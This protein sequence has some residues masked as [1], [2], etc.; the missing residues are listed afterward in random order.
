MH[1]CVAVTSVWPCALQ[2]VYLQA[3]VRSSSV[4]ARSR[5]DANLV[6]PGV[7]MCVCVCTRT[8]DSAQTRGS[9]SIPAKCSHLQTL[10]LHL[11]PDRMLRPQEVTRARVSGV[12]AKPKETRPSDWNTYS[13]GQEISLLLVNP[14]VHCR[15]HKTESLQ[16][17]GP[18]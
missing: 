14:K 15:V 11:L 17:R 12:R 18:S 7:A 4:Y 6:A 1:L 8:A 13:S 2:A 9:M 10:T 5:R 16:I 3:L